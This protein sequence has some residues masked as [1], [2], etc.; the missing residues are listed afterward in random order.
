MLIGIITFIQVHGLFPL[1][2]PW[3]RPELLSSIISALPDS[4]R[5]ENIKFVLFV[6]IVLVE[7]LLL[8]I[9]HLI[10]RQRPYFMKIKPFFIHLPLFLLFL[11]EC[12]N[13]IMRKLQASPQMAG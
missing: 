4:I 13:Y 5:L 8:R 3:S 7:C 1:I 10:L 11:T 2:L 9:T 12:V 6:L